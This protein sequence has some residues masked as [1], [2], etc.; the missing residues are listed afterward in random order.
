MGK[1]RIHARLDAAGRPQTLLKIDPET[2]LA[3]DDKASRSS[4]HAGFSGLARLR[5]RLRR[6]VKRAR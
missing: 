5:Q 6:W 3:I 2:L 4:T 1:D